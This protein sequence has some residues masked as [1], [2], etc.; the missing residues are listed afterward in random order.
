LTEEGSSPSVVI[1][2]VFIKFLACLREG[3]E[4]HWVEK[5]CDMGEGFCGKQIER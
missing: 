5:R 2:D 3:M 1:T 4:R